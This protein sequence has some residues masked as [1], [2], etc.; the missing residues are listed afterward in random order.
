[1]ARP[2]V[3][4][5]FTVNN[6]GYLTVKGITN[7]LYPYTSQTG[8]PTDIYC[9]TV[10]SELW[11]KP[12]ALPWGIVTTT[13]GGT[14]N[15][16]YLAFTT[17]SAT[18]GTSWADLTFG[19]TAMSMTFTAEANRRYKITARIKLTTGLATNVATQ[20][21]IWN[22]SALLGSVQQ[23]YLGSAAS[24]D[25]VY[26]SSVIV[27]PGA[28]SVTYRLRG[29]RIAGTQAYVVAAATDPV[30]MTIEDIGPI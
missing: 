4:C 20:V 12:W 23:G 10:S 5:G 27:A 18:F 15:R 26:E 19:G 16:G 1:M 21:G 22:A 30:W 28:G 2:C 24:D 29:Y 11:L 6:N 25:R 14:N 3:D 17:N 7:A 8:S 13:S 9:D